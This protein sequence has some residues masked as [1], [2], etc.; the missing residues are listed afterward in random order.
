M[1]RA[2]QLSGGAPECDRE[3]SLMRRPWLAKACCVMGRGG[4]Q[5]LAVVIG[6][7][8]RFFLASFFLISLFLFHYTGSVIYDVQ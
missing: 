5:K 6:R 2:D 8:E 4:S 3:A 7:A 1:R